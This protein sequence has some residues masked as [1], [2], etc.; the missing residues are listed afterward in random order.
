[1]TEIPA[2]KKAVNDEP[3][4]PVKDTS[5]E[6]SDTQLDFNAIEEITA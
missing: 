6:A 3:N 4:I 5:M 2:T 1:M